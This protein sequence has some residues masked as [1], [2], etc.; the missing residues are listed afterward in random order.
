MG[1]KIFL[2]LIFVL[3]AASCGRNLPNPVKNQAIV[4]SNAVSIS[5]SG[6]NSSGPTGSIS[7]SG[8]LT[9]PSIPISQGGYF[10]LLAAGS[11]FV[12]RT[13]NS[14][15]KTVLKS[16]FDDQANL[17][18]NRSIQFRVRFTGV[19]SVATCS[20]SASGKCRIITLSSIQAY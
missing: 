13:Q 7:D 9:V 3:T 2:F 15:V 14:N 20:G 18:G 5:A 16:L 19:T 6:S 10:T 12:V 17:G 4:A 11:S 1:S 8:T